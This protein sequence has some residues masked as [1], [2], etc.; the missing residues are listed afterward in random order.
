MPG[1]A[2]GLR[3][4]GQGFRQRPFPP[5]HPFGQAQAV[6][7]LRVNLGV[8]RPVHI[9]QEVHLGSFGGRAPAFVVIEEIVGLRESF[10]GELPEVAFGGEPLAVRRLVQVHKQ[11]RLFRVPLPAQPVDRQI[12]DDVG[13]IALN[14]RI[15]S[16]RDEIGP[17]VMALPGQDHEF[18]KTFRAVA[19]VQLAEHS[20]LVARFL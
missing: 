13:C 18:V 11:K 3:H 17:V 14:G 2:L 9:F 6:H 19:E 1:L 8:A 5:R 4:A 12:S 7:H 10:L 15:S 16:R 20:R